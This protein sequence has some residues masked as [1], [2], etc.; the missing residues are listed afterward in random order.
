MDSAHRK[1]LVR[2]RAAAKSSLTRLQNF[3]EV[4]E[5]KLQDLQVRYEELPNILCKFETAQNELEITDEN[6]YSLDRESFEQQYFQVKAKFIELSHPADTQ[7][8]SADNQGQVDNVEAGN[9]QLPGVNQARHLQVKLPT[10]QLPSYDGTITTWLHFRDTFD[11]LIIQNKMLSNVQ[12]YQYLLSSLKG[13]ARQLIANLQISHDNFVVAWNLVTQRYNNT[14]LLAMTHVKQLLQLPQ[15]K[16]NDSTSLRHLI[17]HV[18]S[19]MNAIQALALNTSMQDLMLNHFMLSVLDSE[20]HKEWELHTA[21]QQD[22]ATTA[23]IIQFLEARCKALELLQASQSTS[24]TTSQQSST[25]KPK[26][27]HSSHCN[28]A[29]KEQCPLCKETHRLVHCG[30]FKGMSSQQRFDYAKQIRACYN[31]LEPYSPLHIC[32]THACHVCNKRH[33]TLLHVNVQETSVS[34]EGFITSPSVTNSTTGQT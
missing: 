32:A 20:T 33:H 30:E 12:K 19:N 8:R 13:E 3:I 21:T 18:T 15:V 1:K 17:N 27:S 34:N 29:T 7:G 10:I 2:Q 24:T 5:C 14:K 26:V 25:L 16:K 22:I 28:L 4:S 9:N 11:S 6:D 31:C 23:T